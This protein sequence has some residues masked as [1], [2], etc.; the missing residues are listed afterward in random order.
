[1]TPEEKAIRDQIKE[2]GRQRYLLERDLK[3]QAKRRQAEAQRAAQE[4]NQS[5]H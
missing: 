1:M 3:E 4:A 2:E 5:Q